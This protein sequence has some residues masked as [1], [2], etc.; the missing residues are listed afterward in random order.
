MF[1][2]RLVAEVAPT[3]LFV[4]S[5]TKDL[6]TDRTRLGELKELAFC[7]AVDSFFFVLFNVEQGCFSLVQCNP[8]LVCSFPDSPL[9]SRIRLFAGWCGPGFNRLLIWA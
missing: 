1:T 4:I 7:V 5:R 8:G 3:A 9:T 2:Q 6:E